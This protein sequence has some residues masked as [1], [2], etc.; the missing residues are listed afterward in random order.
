MVNS[1]PQQQAFR[2]VPRQ[3]S[4][5]ERFRIIPPL[6]TYPW[7]VEFVQEPAGKAALLLIFAL[8]LQRVTIL[9]AL[10]TLI[11]GFIAFL[12]RYRR[13]VL[14]IG[15]LLALAEYSGWLKW[16]VLTG[17]AEQAQ[18]PGEISTGFRATSILLFLGFCALCWH[19][20]IR[21]KDS[22]PARR[23]VRFLL[24][25]YALALLAACSARPGRLRIWLWTF[26]ILLVGYFWALCYSLADRNP[27]GR[28]GFLL[29]L[30]TFHPFWIGAVPTTTPFGKGALYLRNVE[31]KSPA[32][33][34]V[35]QLKGLK[36]L[37]WAL[38]LAAVLDVFVYVVHGQT[39]LLSGSLYIP[40]H[41]NV[42]R[43]TDLLESSAAGA[44]F[45]WYIGWASV[46]A[47]FARTALDYAVMG[48]LIIACCRMAGF[49]AVR[50][51]CR[52][53]RA[54]SIAD[55]WNRYL[56][57]FKE[58]MVEF[59]FF[60][61]YLRYFK[62][63]PRLRLLAAT[64]AAA[65][66]GNAI[67][68]FMRRIEPVAEVGPWRA[69]VGFQS[70]A[71]YT[72]LLSIGIGVSQLRAARRTDGTKTWFRTRVVTPASV[73]LFYCLLH[74]FD[75]TVVTHPLSER[76]GFLMNMFGWRI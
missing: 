12:P 3:A 65:G 13:I 23:P 11:L 40:F 64:F 48:H 26:S 31:A 42:P 34:A 74:V 45:A 41:L 76:F 71:F 52:P 24:L 46:I 21:Y 1:P 49:R 7:L 22:L 66:L 9:W 58:L 16:P 51:T 57:Y 33:F 44:P 18:L 14:T 29:Q 36:L 5:L 53:L 37:L 60:P 15:T 6:E 54:R 32:E 67:Y 25:L 39:G 27:K 62:R 10:L 56:Y 20:V 35:A 69:L 59:F 38:I 30:G 55:F 72:L 63:H 47:D 70:Y 28:D 75:E 4:R 19:L 17:I 68:H 2:S 43:F 50:N 8:G 61:T 73:V